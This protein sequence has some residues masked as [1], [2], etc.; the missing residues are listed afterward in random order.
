VYPGNRDV[1][2]SRGA[3]GI[4]L[5]YNRVGRCDDEVGKMSVRYFRLGAGVAVLLVVVLVSGA[6]ATNAHATGAPP[7][8]DVAVASLAPT[9]KAVTVGTDPAIATYDPANREVYVGNTGSGTVSAV[10]STSYVVKSIAVGK[11]PLDIVYSASSKDVYVENF[12]SGNISILSSSNKVVHSV[13]LPGTPFTEVYDPANGDVYVVTI[14]ASGT[15]ASDINHTTW[16]VK[17]VKLGSDA[18]YSAYDN[19]S[20]SL[21]F[22]STALNALTVVSAKDVTTTVNLTVGKTPAFMVYNPSDKDLY[23]SDLGESGTG[24][25]KTGNVS[26]LSS[27]NKIIATIKVGESPFYGSYDPASH[28][29]FEVNTGGLPSGKSY[30]TTSVSVI[31][32]GNTVLT[33]LTLGKGGAVATYD[34]NN[35]EM[36]VSCADSNKTYAI[37]STT[38]KIA[39]TVKTTQYASAAIPDPALGDEVAVG[40]PEFANST[41]TTRTI[42]TLIPASNTGTSTLTLGIGPTGGFVYDPADSGLWIV[43]GGSKSVSIIL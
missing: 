8:L 21:V 39:A 18:Y 6:T 1:D 42:V 2:W 7:R 26:V 5:M 43:N 3:T 33:T 14:G 41:S 30:P 31:G 35:S 13:T 15:L 9:V 20:S 10:N 25:T 32:T 22:A 23:V 29:I 36:Y 24:Y 4:F 38:N 16:S 34:P 17:N 40:F 12:E 37:N 11:D 19:A 28:D 27:A